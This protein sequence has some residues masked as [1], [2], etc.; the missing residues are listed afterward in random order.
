M[1][2]RGAIVFYVV[3][4]ILYDSNLGIKEYV[5]NAFIVCMSYIFPLFYSTIFFFGVLFL[6]I[7]SFASDFNFNF[8]YEFDVNIE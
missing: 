4:L 2:F 6:L 3:L 8:R 1:F 5:G 7:Y